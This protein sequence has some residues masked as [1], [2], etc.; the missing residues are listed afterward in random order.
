MKEKQRTQTEKQKKGELKT[1]ENRP[2][3]KGEN[4]ENEENRQGKRPG[5]QQDKLK[6][7]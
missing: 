1:T 4:K 5:T 6:K 3:L 7:T 2:G